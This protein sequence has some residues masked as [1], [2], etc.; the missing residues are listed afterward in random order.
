MDNFKKSYS[1]KESDE[2]LEPARLDL[3]K[4]YG[5]LS[6]YDNKFYG[7]KNGA[8]NIYSFISSALDSGQWALLDLEYTQKLINEHFKYLFLKKRYSEVLIESKNALLYDH[9]GFYLGEFKFESLSEVKR[10]L[11]NKSFI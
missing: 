10:A 9:E 2:S 5:L 6:Y 3:T 1:Y 8:T 7:H 4:E 11:A